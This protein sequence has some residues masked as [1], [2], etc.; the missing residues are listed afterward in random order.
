MD[1]RA[2]RGDAATMGE[3]GEIQP[4]ATARIGDSC[5]GLEGDQATGRDVD[6]LEPA[7]LQHAIQA[8]GREPRQAERGA[9]EAP[10]DTRSGTQP[11]D[12]RTGSWV[13]RIARVQ[14]DDRVARI[15]QPSETEP[16]STASGVPG[17][18]G[19]RLRA[20]APDGSERF[21]MDRVVHDPEDHVRVDREGDADR[22][23]RDPRRE[24]DRAVD[25]VDDPGPLPAATAAAR[26]RSMLLA[27]ESIIREGGP[28]PAS[29]QSLGPRVVRGDHVMWAVPV[30]SPGPGRLPTWPHEGLEEQSARLLRGVRGRGLLDGHP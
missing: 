29:D 22:E 3:I 7:D 18:P 21:V 8:T 27:D 13:V 20:G 2:G 14:A 24:H 28:Q 9:A 26:A 15:S 17:D 30:A 5:P 25:R 11:L 1:R 23:E 4:W 6:R 12:A 16:A 19:H 10:G